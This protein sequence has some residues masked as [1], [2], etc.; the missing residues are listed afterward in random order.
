MKY[1]QRALSAAFALFALSLG[2][3]GQQNRPTSAT[4]PVRANPET[5]PS[6]DAVPTLNASTHLVALDVVVTD[7]KGHT[8]PGL[9]QDDFHI[10]ED[11]RPEAV[12]FFEEMRRSIQLWSQ[13][14]GLS[15]PRSFR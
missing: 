1:S 13:S 10:F 12:R 8:V 11:G 3:R 15:W 14:R 7:K 5:L 2:M 4:E 9:T 6:E